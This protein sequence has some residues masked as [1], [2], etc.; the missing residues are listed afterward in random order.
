[1]L[2]GDLL[3]Y[4][5]DLR[6]LVGNEKKKALD[7]A[8]SSTN[9]SDVYFRP[10]SELSKGYRQRVGLSIALLHKPKVLILDEPS[11]GLDPNQ[12]GETRKLIRQL[13]KKHTVIISTHVMQEVEALCS[14]V[15]VINKGKIVADDS[16]SKLVRNLKKDRVVTIDIEG[17]SVKTSLKD[18]KLEDIEIEEKKRNRFEVRIKVDSKTLIQPIISNLVSK[19]KWIIWGL[20]EDKPQLEDVFK[21]LTE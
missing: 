10:I 16:V 13:A 8:V 4:S 1:M 9:I 2:V 18:L 19:N 7:F 17:K 21:E 15:V 6:G 20:T 14:R 11:E 12:R 5:S 3:N